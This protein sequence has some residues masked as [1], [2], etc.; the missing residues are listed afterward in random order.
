MKADIYALD[1]GESIALMEP[2]VVSEGSQYRTEL[3]DLSIELASKSASFKS[4]LP[5]GVRASLANLV[6]AMNCYYSN[7]I[8]G[9]DTH[10]IDIERAL[11]NDLSSNIEK[12]NLQ[13]EAKAHISVQEWIDEG[14][15]NGRATSTVSLLEIHSR[16]YN[17]LPEALR[18]SQTSVAGPSSGGVS[19]EYNTEPVLPG[20]L[21]LHEVKVGQH[22][23]VSA[24]A[25]PRFLDR[26]ET[27]Y[28]QLGKTN[29][30]LAS[31]SAHHRVLWVHPFL[32]GNGRVAR[33]MSHAMLRDA[34]NTGGL[35]SIARGLERHESDY[36][37]LLM[38][39]DQTRRNDVDGRGHLSEAALAEFSVFFLNICIDQVKFMEGLVQPERL[40]NRI[41]L[42]AEEE[43]RA[44]ALPHKSDTILEAIL[45]RGELAKKEVA[46]IVGASDRHARRITSALIQREILISESPRSALRLAFPAALASRWM[47]GLFPDVS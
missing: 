11:R 30:I 34:L 21:R 44:N 47:P 39:C 42:W 18:W 35:W 8:E 12:R 10:P 28:H 25:L 40:R 3:T 6:R 20:A 24:G 2:M 22:I 32:D 38:A 13:L 46:G 36:K 23:A 14:G 15:L 26:F 29:A 37:R 5:E 7:L 9:H 4:S 33:L 43:I 1:R 16:F 19:G 41:L 27:A 31:A 45:Y 17:A